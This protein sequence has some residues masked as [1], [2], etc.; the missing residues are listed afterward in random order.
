M[1][2]PIIAGNWK[3]VKTAAETRAFVK[4]F[5]PLVGTPGDREVVLCSPFTAARNVQRS[6]R[7]LQVGGNADDFLD[8]CLVGPRDHLGQFL[9]KIGV[10]QV[11][12]GIDEH[13]T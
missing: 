2:K 8:A 3:M 7:C 6:P 13:R 5:R 10:T 1:R 4:A 9:G 11:G 12:M